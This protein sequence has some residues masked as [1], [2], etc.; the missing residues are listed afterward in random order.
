VTL[1]RHAAPLHD[2]GKLAIPDCIL[3][4]PGRL[5]PEEFDVMKTHAELGARLLSSGSSRVL[6]TAAVIA[7]THHERWDGAG[8]PKGLAGDAIPL[9]GRI[10]AV[11]DVFDA[12][13][14]DRPYK[15]A[16]P[17][18][19][20]CAEI[21]RS[22][23]GQFDPRVVVAFRALRTDLDAV[24][25]ELGEPWLQSGPAIFGGRTVPALSRRRGEV[26]E[27]VDRHAPRTEAGQRRRVKRAV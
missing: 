8:Y 5:T 3:L 23:G 15:Q 21:E 20:A 17:I 16:W 14:H 22:A 9:V 27:Q 18:E 4:K 10:V 19:R 13:T 7:A 2:V 6:Q 11:A 12:L 25:D 1:L 26:L 24:G